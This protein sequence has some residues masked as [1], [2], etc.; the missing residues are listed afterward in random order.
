MR[1]GREIFWDFFVA[2]RPEPVER[3]PRQNP[4]GQGPQAEICHSTHRKSTPARG[5]GVC[6]SGLG[7][8][9]LLHCHKAEPAKETELAKEGGKGLC[10]QTAESGTIPDL[11]FS[12]VES[13]GHG[14]LP[15]CP[16]KKCHSDLP[17][18]GQVSGHASPRVRFL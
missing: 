9:G 18:W 6:K 10:T 1:L 4:V 7:G 12:P 13:T 16:R 8:W 2:K 5:M 11:S 3:A 14:S 15:E 17:C